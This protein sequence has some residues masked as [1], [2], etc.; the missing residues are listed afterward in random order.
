MDIQRRLGI[1]IQLNAT[2]QLDQ[3]ALAGGGAVI[4]E[5]LG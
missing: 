5:Q 2:C 1:Q 3:S 4:T